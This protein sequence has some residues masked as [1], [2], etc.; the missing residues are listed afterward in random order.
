M[1]GAATLR[2]FLFIFLSTVIRRDFPM[3]LPSV[4]LLI[5]ILSSPEN[6]ER[7]QEVRSTWAHYYKQSLGLSRQWTCVCIRWREQGRGDRT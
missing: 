2:S 4:R 6:F 3:V 5:G 7:R 1:H